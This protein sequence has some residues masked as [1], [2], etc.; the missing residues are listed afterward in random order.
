MSNINTGSNR[1]TTFIS[2]D[3]IYIGRTT[4][5]SDRAIE[6]SDLDTYIAATALGSF[7]SVTIADGAPVQTIGCGAYASYH[8]FKID[9]I[10]SSTTNRY[11]GHIILVYDNSAASA[12]SPQISKRLP[13]GL[14]IQQAAVTAGQFF[15]KITNNSGN[16]TTI[17]YKVTQFDAI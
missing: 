14:N 3:I 2:G 13:G 4:D 6:K 8:G 12:T 5:N 17:K 10:L 15:W 16:S 1:I 7:S 9:F 11:V